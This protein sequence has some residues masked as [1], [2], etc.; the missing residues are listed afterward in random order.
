MKPQN[1]TDNFTIEWRVGAGVGNTIQGDDSTF[2]INFL[3]EQ[4]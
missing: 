4:Q 2:T 3:L 1:D